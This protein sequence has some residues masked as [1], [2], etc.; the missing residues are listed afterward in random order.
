MLDV[1]KPL[2]SSAGYDLDD[3]M[4]RARGVCVYG[5][6]AAGCDRADSD[7]DVLVLGIPG[8]WRVRRAGIDLSFEDPNAPGWLG[9]ELAIHVTRYSIWLSGSMPWRPHDL[10]WDEAEDFKLKVLARTAAAVRR[11]G[12]A[13]ALNQVLRMRA[14]LRRLEHL[15]RREYVPPRELLTRNWDRSLFP[16]LEPVLSGP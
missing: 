2:V 9:R 8:P 7:W 6:R 10:R 3:L 11:R 14:D 15:R 1:L 16:D 4:R 5:S 12:P 13:A